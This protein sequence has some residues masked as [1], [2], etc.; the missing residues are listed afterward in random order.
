[1]TTAKEIIFSMF[2][3]LKHFTSGG[4]Q[5][6]AITEGELEMIVTTISRLL[7]SLLILTIDVVL[8]LSHISKFSNF[9]ISKF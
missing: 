4:V 3:P 9:K 2:Y 7:S 5:A 6:R 1:M 8:S